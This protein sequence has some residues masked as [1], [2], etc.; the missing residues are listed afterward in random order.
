M[1]FFKVILNLFDGD[2]GAGAAGEGGSGGEGTKAAINAEVAARGRSLGLSDD[3]LQVYNDAFGAKD[4]GD[5]EAEAETE[6]ETQEDTEE[7]IDSEFKELIEGKYAN[8]YKKAMSA[9][10]KDRVS[11]ANRERADLQKQLD[12]GNRILKMLEGK[13][14][15]LDPNDPDALY[16]AVRD[17]GDIWRERAIE[18]GGS[19]EEAVNAFDNAQKQ[20]SEREELERYRRQDRARQLDLHFQELAKEVVKDYPDFDLQRE[21][22]NRRFTQAL[23]VIAQNNADENRRTGRNDEIYDLKYAYEIAH[24]DELRENVIKRTSK[25][26]ASAYAQT[27]AARRGRIKENAAGNGTPGAK[28][29]DILHMSDDDFDRLVRDVKSGKRSIPG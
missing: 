24:A 28:H 7:K 11:K 18:T 8:S 23:D 1:R 21:F 20:E 26:T 25:A 3:M 4:D 13:Y 6:T 5:E 12:S 17:D 29:V 10:V 16:K 22:E 15:G 2:G 9:A 27:L 14:E 19:I